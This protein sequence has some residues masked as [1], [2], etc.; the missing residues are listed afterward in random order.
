M[1]CLAKAIYHEARGEG[2]RGMLAVGYVVINRA[3]HARFPSDICDVVKQPN[4]FSWVGV[5][6]KIHDSALY[7]QAK[8][9]AIMVAESSDGDPTKGSTHFHRFDLG[10]DWSNKSMKKTVRI[11]NH[12]FYRL[13]D[14]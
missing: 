3:N 4:Q 7:E 12:Q 1:I 9:V 10:I 8:S 11:G 5:K 6:M 13:S 2:I 14:K